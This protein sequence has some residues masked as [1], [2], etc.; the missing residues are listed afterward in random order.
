MKP[1]AAAAAAAAML[2][3]FTT[4]TVAGDLI[5]QP[6]PPGVGLNLVVEGTACSGI[7]ATGFDSSGK[8]L[9]CQSGVWTGGTPT[10]GGS[11]IGT[12]INYRWVGSRY[13]YAYEICRA[14]GTWQTIY[15]NII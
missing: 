4:I 1:A 11:P 9:A 13:V 7:G 15:D 2:A 8:M 5:A 3:L 14:D 6:S 12:A 10:C